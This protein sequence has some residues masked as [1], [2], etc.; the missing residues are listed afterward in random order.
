[1]AWLWSFALLALLLKEAEGSAKKHNQAMKSV[2]VQLAKFFR[3]LGADIKV[4][5]LGERSLE[6]PLQLRAG[7]HQHVHQ[8]RHPPER[9]EVAEV[10][11]DCGAVQRGERLAVRLV[12]KVV[13]VVLLV[14][15]VVV[16]V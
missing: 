10:G 7:A 1:M 8:L 16:V 4:I 12:K 15:V 5:R 6:F 14:V 13:A 2:R 9:A 3:L 11:R